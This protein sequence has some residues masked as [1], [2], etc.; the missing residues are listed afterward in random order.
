MTPFHK[1]NRAKGRQPRA[2]MCAYHRPPCNSPLSYPHS[3]Y[4]EDIAE[5]GKERAHTRRRVRTQG[6]ARERMVT[7]T[8][9]AREGEFT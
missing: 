7:V 9:R 5:L 1:R 6:R 2:A 4:I 8:T 3:R